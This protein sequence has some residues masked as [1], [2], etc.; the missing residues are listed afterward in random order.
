MMSHNF[1]AKLIREIGKSVSSHQETDI[2]R[3]NRL[4]SKI[5]KG[6]SISFENRDDAVAFSNYARRKGYANSLYMPA[7]NEAYMVTFQ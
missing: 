6:G 5:R 7:E 2:V 1:F 3:Y 4:L